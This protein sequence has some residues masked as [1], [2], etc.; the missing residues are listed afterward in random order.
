MI[1]ISTAIPQL[2]PISS[3]K[4]NPIHI[5]STNKPT[6]Q[7]NPIPLPPSQQSQISNLKPQT[8]P[9]F[10]F[11]FLSSPLYLPNQLAMYPTSRDSLHSFLN[12]T[13]IHSMESL[14]KSRFGD[15]WMMMMMD[16][17]ME[18]FGFIWV[19]GLL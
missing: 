6:N 9:N 15:G 2:R 13:D 19:D 1:E 17:G 3:P 10:S 4:P 7:S 5:I 18:F 12:H 16:G 8:S 14:H 11:P